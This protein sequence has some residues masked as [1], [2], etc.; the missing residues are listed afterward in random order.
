MR[1]RCIENKRPSIMGTTKI[2][3][4]SINGVY[5]SIGGVHGNNIVVFDDS[6]VWDVY[7]I[8]WFIPVD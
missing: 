4:L 8:Q 6:K 7:P 1:L 5:C 3:P 2:E